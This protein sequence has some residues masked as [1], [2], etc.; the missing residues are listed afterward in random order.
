MGSGPITSAIELANTRFT[1]PIHCSPKWPGRDSVQAG[2]DG[3]VGVVRA[4]LTE[5]SYSSP[6]PACGHLL[7]K[8]G[9]GLKGWGQEPL[10]L[11]TRRA[12]P[13]N[14]S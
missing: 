6:H 14:G 7:P 10:V 13:A 8:K 3:V 4:G 5:A 12:V 11:S 9:E 1:L 2:R